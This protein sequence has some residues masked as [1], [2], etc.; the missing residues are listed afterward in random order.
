MPDE[1]LGDKG[2][3]DAPAAKAGGQSLVGKKGHGGDGS[4]HEGAAGGLPD[5]GGEFWGGF[6]IAHGSIKARKR[7]ESKSFGFLMDDE[8]FARAAQVGSFGAQFQ[9]AV[10]E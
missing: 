8:A 3:L 5:A 9:V 1:A 6:W 2:S 10:G 4:G 7:P